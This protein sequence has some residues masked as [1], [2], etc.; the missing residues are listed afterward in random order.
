MSHFTSIETQFKDIDALKEAC[1]ELGL[2]VVANGLARG[3]ARNQTAGEFVIRLSGPYDAALNRQ[4]DGTYAVTADM[5]Q[6]HVER[7]LGT[8]LCRLRQF[9]GVHKAAREAQAR[10]YTVRR[11]TQPNGSISLSLCRA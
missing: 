9:Y 8:G 4:P 5:W 1:G 7:E 6:G 11:Q 3:Y 10:G 2:Q